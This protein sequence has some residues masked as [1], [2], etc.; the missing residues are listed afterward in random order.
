MRTERQGKR[1]DI[2]KDISGEVYFLAPLDEDGEE[3]TTASAGE[4][5]E[6]GPDPQAEMCVSVATMATIWLLSELEHWL[7][8]GRE[9]RGREGEGLVRWGYLNMG[10]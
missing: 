4:D 5:D 7:D 6:N 2:L 10:E 3:G 8:G 1:T 9:R